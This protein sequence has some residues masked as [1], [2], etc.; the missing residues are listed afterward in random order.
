MKT[1]L[2]VFGGGVA[3]G[4]VLVFAAACRRAGALVD[5]QLKDGLAEL[6]ALRASGQGPLTV[7]DVID[8][9]NAV[10]PTPRPDG[11]IVLTHEQVDQLIRDLETLTG[12]PDDGNNER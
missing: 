10:R 9:A 3:A 12:H 7:G 1:V 4:L 5:Q 6:D 2:I 8:R 11:Y